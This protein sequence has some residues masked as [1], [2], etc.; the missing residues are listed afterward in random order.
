MVWPVSVVELVDSPSFLQE[1]TS[2]GRVQGDAAAAATGTGWDISTARGSWHAADSSSAPLCWQAKV[3]GAA[4]SSSCHII[5]F[6]M[7][8]A[9]LAL[10][11]V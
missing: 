4:C 1:E 3:R 8:P 6:L 5:T 9:G 7:S 10:P 2:T 11:R